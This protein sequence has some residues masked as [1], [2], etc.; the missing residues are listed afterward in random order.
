M[1]CIFVSQRQDK[2]KQVGGRS[3][4][5]SI[6]ISW[7]QFHTKPSQYLLVFCSKR[8][9]SY[10]EI[11]YFDSICLFKCSVVMSCQGIPLWSEPKKQQHFFVIIL[12][13]ASLTIWIIYFYMGWM[14]LDFLACWLRQLVTNKKLS[15]FV[16]INYQLSSILIISSMSLI[17]FNT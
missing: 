6:H 1:F 16:V 4:Y 17:F 8:E 11:L 9:C 3:V 2:Q 5:L 7:V 15:K 13:W 14:K 12:F 10:W